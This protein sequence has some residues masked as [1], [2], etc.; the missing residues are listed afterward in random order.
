MDEIAEIS[1]LDLVDLREQAHKTLVDRKRAIEIAAAKEIEAYEAVLAEQE[2]LAAAP[3][4]P[5]LSQEIESWLDVRTVARPR[6]NCTE[7][8][9]A[10][11]VLRRLIDC[12]P[13]LVSGWPIGLREAR[14]G[15]DSLP[16]YTAY[17]YKVR[18]WPWFYARHRLPNSLLV[19]AF[20]LLLAHTG[21]NPASVGALTVDAITKLPTGGYR[22][23]SYKSKTDDE[24]PVSEVP[25]N[26]KLLCKAIDLL[27]WNYEQLTATNCIDPKTEKRLWFGWQED[28]YKNVQNFISAARVTKWCERTGITPFLP[29]ELR[30]LAA[31][32]AYLPQRDLEAV[33]VLLGH[34]NLQTTDGYLENT[35]FFR[36]NEAM[37]LEFQR[38]IETSIAYSQ[39]G[40]AVL[41]SRGLQ[42]RHL[43]AKLLIPTGD[44]GVCTDVMAGPIH[45]T[46]RKDEPCPG[47]SC[48]TGNGCKHYRLTVT[49]TTLEMAFR[50]RLYYRSRWQSLWDANP[51]AFSRLH[52]P[53]LLYIYV[54]LRIVSD[55]RPDI[56]RRAEAA[57]A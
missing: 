29:S 56:Y 30:P 55:Q 6:P 10:S 52:L 2:Q 48:Q 31:A 43:D 32:L 23:Q 47:I 8:E 37:M 22:L 33:R 49:P 13:E 35:L 14:F 24:T 1:H 39:G 34:S 26:L 5:R 53:R 9:F 46:H 15:L 18:V 50:T 57:I 4:S 25:R 11:I 41:Q 28:G 20:I 3:V 19:T 42:M 27:L 54:L 17:R 36:L 40:E 12:P 44:G 38:R 7:R 51:T 21:W 45:R 16:Q